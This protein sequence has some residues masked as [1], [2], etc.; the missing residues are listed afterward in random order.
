VTKI[1]PDGSGYFEVS[2]NSSHSLEGIVSN[3]NFD[4][5]RYVTVKD[6]QY[7]KFSRASV[8]VK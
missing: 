6:G 3:G 1:I 8:V 2:S 4:T 7:L 5:E